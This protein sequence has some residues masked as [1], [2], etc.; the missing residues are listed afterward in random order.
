MSDT[1]YYPCLGVQKINKKY[2]RDHLASDD[3]LQHWKVSL[4]L[5]DHHNKQGRFSTAEK[6]ARYQNN[7]LELENK[8]AAEQGYKEAS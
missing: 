2:Y 6:Q 7:R 1:R 8:I 4:A 3:Q 5:L